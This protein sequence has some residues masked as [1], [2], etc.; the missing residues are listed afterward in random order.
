MYA[1]KCPNAGAL[2]RK[3]GLGLRPTAITTGEWRVLNCN[4]ARAMCSGFFFFFN[5]TTH[6]GL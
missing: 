5:A 6:E 1:R 2:Q 3:A 4:N